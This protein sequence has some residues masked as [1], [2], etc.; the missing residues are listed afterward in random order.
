M[1][2]LVAAML[3]A[4]G[5]HWCYSALVM[6]WRGFGLGPSNKTRSKPARR[7]FDAWLGRVGLLNVDKGQFLGVVAVLFAAAGL[8][9][10]VMFGS[11]LVAALVGLFAATFPV[12]AYQVR[13]DTRRQ[14]AQEAWPQMI[15]EIRVQTG[16]LGRS[17][18]QAL[19]DVGSRS[20]AEMRPAFEA[21]LRE[22]RLTTDLQR[23]LSVLK[24]GL[25]DPTADAACET[26]LVAHEVGGG[27]LDR[28]LEALAED[29]RGDIQGRKDARSRQSGARFARLF[30][31]FVP[32]GMAAAGMSI[33]N[34]RDAYRSPTGQLV[35]IAA[36]LLVM[37]CWMW[38]GRVMRLPQPRRVFHQ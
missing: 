12:G 37:G 28:R 26:L 9:A 27:D 6:G 32:L 35:V 8:L 5:A 20:P 30:V 22:W 18:P 19:F 38:A 25:A 15:E 16:S 7:R 23:A 33:G 36:L 29:R 10:H 34:G 21:S 24:A 4:L 3:A 11:V 2:A 14:R 13:A 31:I 17:I 1:T